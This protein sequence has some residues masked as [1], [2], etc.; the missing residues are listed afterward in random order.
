MMADQDEVAKEIKCHP[1]IVKL[2]MADAG[3]L[4]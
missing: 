4:T 2:V 1:E 3:S